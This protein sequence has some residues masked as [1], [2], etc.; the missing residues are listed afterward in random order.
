MLL[1]YLARR[2]VI[3]LDIIHRTGELVLT[4]NSMS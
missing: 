4:R 3:R 2:A 1:V